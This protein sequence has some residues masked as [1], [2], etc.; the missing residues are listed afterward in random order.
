[1]YMY[2]YI[3]IYSISR[4]APTSWTVGP[5]G[6]GFRSVQDEFITQKYSSHFC[7]WRSL[8]RLNHGLVC[9]LTTGQINQPRTTITLTVPLLHQAVSSK[10]GRSS[11]Y[12]LIQSDSKDSVVKKLRFKRRIY[13]WCTNQSHFLIVTSSSYIVTLSIP[14]GKRWFFLITNNGSMDD[15]KVFP[16]IHFGNHQ[17]SFFS[18]ESLPSRKTHPAISYRDPN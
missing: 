12:L 9:R 18:F 7:E 17:T 4:Q 16:K 6:R 11:C 8:R 13:Q 5:F 2:M 10:R 1:M 15:Q 14:V 3:Y